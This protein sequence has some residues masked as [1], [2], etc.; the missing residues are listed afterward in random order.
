MKCRKAQKM[1]SARFDGELDTKRLADLEQHLTG[2][3][4]CRQ[5]SERLAC[6]EQALEL[7]TVSEPSAD[8]TDRVL[9]RLPEAEPRTTGVTSWIHAIRP[10][11]AAAAVVGLCSGAVLAL[12]MNGDT[13]PHLDDRQNP[14]DAVLLQSFEAIPGDSAEAR[15]LV[16]LQEG[17]K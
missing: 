15:Y 7:L 11:R 8:F 5:F 14:A 13:P 12:S 16:L 3:H 2:C 1:L 17:G 4:P 6:S 10:A 9:A